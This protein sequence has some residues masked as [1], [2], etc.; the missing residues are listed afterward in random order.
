MEN[1]VF[2]FLSFQMAM[3]DQV[4][5]LQKKRDYLMET[6]LRYR[7]LFIPDFFIDPYAFDEDVPGANP[8]KRPSIKASS[9]AL[10]Y[11]FRQD[12]NVGTKIWSIYFE[13]ISNN[14]EPGYWDDVERNIETQHEDGSA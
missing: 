11:A 14:M 2:W 1:A 7:H 9:V 6:N 4:E 8:F 12:L 13:Y 10:E 3:A 5:G